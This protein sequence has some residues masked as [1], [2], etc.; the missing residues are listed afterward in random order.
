M[1]KIIITADS[2]CDLSEELIN[3]YNVVI[4]PLIVSMGDETFKDGVS[5]DPQQIF[6]YVSKTHKLP[7]TAAPSPGDYAELFKSLKEQGYQEI[8]HISISS[9]FSS[10]YQNALIAAEETGGVYVVDSYNLSTGSGHIVVEAGEKIKE[11][12]KQADKIAEYLNDLVS[13]VDASFVVDTLEYLHR[14]GRCSSVAA[15]GANLLKLKPCIEVKNGKMDVGRK[16]RGNMKDVITRYITD[17][18]TEKDVKFKRDRIFITHTCVTP[19]LVEHARQLVESYGIFNEILETKAGS[20][21]TS[22]CG[23]DTLGILYIKD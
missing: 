15:L 7:K 2:T 5:V 13:K 16:Y 12:V 21:I 18:L 14:G 10:S 1:D 4:M 19:G 17:R 6:S 11:G 8:I 3:K 9:F 20:T 23:P 22:H